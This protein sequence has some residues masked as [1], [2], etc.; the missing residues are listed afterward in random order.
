MEGAWIRSTIGYHAGLLEEFSCSWVVDDNA[1]T[2]RLDEVHEDV[3]LI[4]VFA[5][6]LIR[7]LAL[8]ARALR[9]QAEHVFCGIA[10]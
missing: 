9:V 1:M 8:I 4:R 10:A 7:G 3:G 5:P 2:A 6:I